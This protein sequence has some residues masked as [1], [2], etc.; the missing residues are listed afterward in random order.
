MIFDTFTVSGIIVVL[1]FI[2]MAVTLKFCCK[3]K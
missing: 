1:A 3:G 2:A